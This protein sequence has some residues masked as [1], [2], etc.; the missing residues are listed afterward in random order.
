MYYKDEMTLKE[1]QVKNFGISNHSEYSIKKA[2]DDEYI[3]KK[4]K[5]NRYFYIVIDEQSFIDVYRDYFPLKKTKNS[6][7]ILEIKM[8]E[9]RISKAYDKILSS[10]LNKDLFD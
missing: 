10:K 7:S 9:E 4:K 8:K 3:V 2:I 5:G 1:F 6:L